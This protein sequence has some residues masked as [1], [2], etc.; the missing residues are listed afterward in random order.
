VKLRAEAT[1]PASR[2]DVFAALSRAV[3][4]DSMRVFQLALH[5]IRA[6]N[7]LRRLAT[8]TAHVDGPIIFNPGFADNRDGL[9]PAVTV[10]GSAP[11]V[12]IPPPIDKAY[13]GAERP[14]FGS[15]IRLGRG[16]CSAFCQLTPRP[17]GCNR[18]SSAAP[19]P[20]RAGH[21]TLAYCAVPCA[22]P[23]TAPVCRTFV[24][25]QWR[26]RRKGAWTHLESDI[27][28]PP[29]QVRIEGCSR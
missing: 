8:L 27:A 9:V 25:V 5:G 28:A 16:S 13:N 23:R 12:V 15:S 1:A 14:T 21:A 26:P 17:R 10:S 18:L 3:F 7:A 20:R 24:H 4:L 19:R 29:Q 6:S 22:G 11:V 2:E